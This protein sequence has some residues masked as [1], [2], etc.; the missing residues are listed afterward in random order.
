MKRN[1]T[2]NR[3]FFIMLFIPC[4]LIS[5]SDVADDVNSFPTVDYTELVQ[6]DSY[7][8]P[9]SADALTVFNLFYNTFGYGE[10]SVSGTATH[11]ETEKLIENTYTQT[12]TCNIEKI[13][14][15]H[16]DNSTSGLTVSSFYV[17]FIN[18][19]QEV[20]TYCYQWQYKN[21]N[22]WKNDKTSTWKQSSDW[23]KSANNATRIDW[24]IS[25]VR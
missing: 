4:F 15:Y 25:I 1:N 16:T 7:K 9:S 11:T 17:D 10:F 20:M 2:N 21:T 3:F 12:I 18:E 8:I 24:N 6:D 14:I 13:K 5:C 19:D 23:Y 22:A